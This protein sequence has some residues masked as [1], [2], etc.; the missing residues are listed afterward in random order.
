M[1]PMPWTEKWH[2]GPKLP[3]KNERCERL[4]AANTPA[5]SEEE[6]SDIGEV[7][8]ALEEERRIAGERRAVMAHADFAAAQRLASANGMKLISHGDQYNLAHETAGWLV[9]LYPSNQRIYRPKG[10]KP[11]SPHITLDQSGWT[12]M[13]VVEA[14]I[15]ASKASDRIVPAATNVN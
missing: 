7:Y 10:R 6:V 4:V 3:R 1:S 5:R 9:Q 14:F 2:C 12:L 11:Y 15:E 13:S 8:K